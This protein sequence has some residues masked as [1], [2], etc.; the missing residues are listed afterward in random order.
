MHVG[1][2]PVW[3]APHAASDIEELEATPIVRTEMGG[4]M[5]KLV[6]V[7]GPKFGIVVPFIPEAVRASP[8]REQ[9][10]PRTSRRFQL[11][12]RVENAGLE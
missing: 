12:A 9:P 7:F 10:V 8:A 11:P 4:P 5:A 6:L 1:H 2:V 3:I